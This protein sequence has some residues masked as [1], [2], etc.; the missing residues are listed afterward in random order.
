VAEV[1]VLGP[2]GVASAEASGTAR[3]VA[4]LPPQPTQPVAA[5]GTYPVRF[6]TR[7][8]NADQALAAGR[9]QS[10]ALSTQSAPPPPAPSTAP[11]P[12]PPLSSAPLP[13]GTLRSKK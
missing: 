6:E 13:S 1:Q 12:A 4:G 3:V 2:A 11:L 9:P 8:G 10:A 5:R 7:P